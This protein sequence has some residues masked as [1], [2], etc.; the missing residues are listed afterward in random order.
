MNIAVS[1]LPLS[2]CL[3][4]KVFLTNLWQRNITFWCQWASP[5]LLNVGFSV[6]FWVFQLYQDRP[7]PLNF[8]A[9]FFPY[10]PGIKL[11]S[12]ASNTMVRN[13][14]G[15]QNNRKKSLKCHNF[16]HILTHVLILNLKTY[17][18]VTI[19]AYAVLT[20]WIMTSWFVLQRVSQQNHSFIPFCS[21][22]LLRIC[23]VQCLIWS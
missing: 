4:L 15:S 5:S 18:K 22:W 10:I 21:D 19:L 16:W 13:Y 6:G 8:P 2:T 7:V 3:L 11:C 9:S 20:L 12:I 1:C 23:L 14:S 17:L